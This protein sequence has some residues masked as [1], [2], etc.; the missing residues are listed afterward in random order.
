MFLKCLRLGFWTLAYFTPFALLIILPYNLSH[1]GPGGDKY[2][3]QGYFATTISN[4]D[5]S[6]GEKGLLTPHLAATVLINFIFMVLLFNLHLDYI[7]LRRAFSKMRAGERTVFV[8]GIPER[9]RSTILLR[10][11]FD[12]MYNGDVQTVQFI[13]HVSDLDKVVASREVTVMQLERSLLTDKLRH[14]GQGK[15]S[16]RI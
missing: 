13:K 9:L 7:E 15:V 12:V 14:Q 1:E 16:Q 6:T 2:Y 5:S 11:Y 3:A 4:I 8:T 10:K